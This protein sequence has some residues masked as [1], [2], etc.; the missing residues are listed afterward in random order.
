[1]IANRTKPAIEEEKGC[2]RQIAAKWSNSRWHFPL[3]VG[4]AASMMP[5]FILGGSTNL[6][7]VWDSAENKVIRVSNQAAVYYDDVRLVYQITSRLRE[8][9]EQEEV[10]AHQGEAPHSEAAIRPT[11]QKESAE[12]YTHDICKVN[13]KAGRHFPLAGDPSAYSFGCLQTGSVSL[14]EAGSGTPTA[15]LGRGL[16]GVRTRYAYLA[17]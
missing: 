16:S 3:R 7:T 2:L 13:Y 5:F 11:A 1:M 14:N 17:C 10:A 9:Q 12:A 15:F 8:L 6:K 4:I